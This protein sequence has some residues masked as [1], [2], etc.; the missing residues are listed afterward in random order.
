MEPDLK[1]FEDV[2]LNIYEFMLRS[3][4]LLPRVETKLYAEWVAVS[5]GVAKDDFVS[6]S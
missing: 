5:Q 1:S 3:V 2:L 6:I 4:T